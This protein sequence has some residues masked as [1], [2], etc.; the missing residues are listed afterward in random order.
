[1]GVHVSRTPWKLN[2][3]ASVHQVKG[4]TAHHVEANREDSD[5]LFITRVA[6]YAH[7]Y[8]K[9]HDFGRKEQ[10]PGNRT[11]VDSI[12]WQRDAA[13]TWPSGRS[14]KCDGKSSSSS[15]RKRNVA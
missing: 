11:Q 15:A 4:M 6:L 8:N 12:G 5:A 10:G 1:M 9:V 2:L 3:R 7:W 13:G 14:A